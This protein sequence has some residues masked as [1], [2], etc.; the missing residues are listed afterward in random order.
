MDYTSI[1]QYMA[2]RHIEGHDIIMARNFKFPLPI[3]IKDRV[4]LVPSEDKF[5]NLLAEY[6]ATLELAGAVR[7]EV[8]Q[9]D[10]QHQKGDGVSISVVKSFYNPQGQKVCTTDVTYFGRM[11]DGKA[12]FHMVECTDFTSLP[13]TDDVVGLQQA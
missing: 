2:D 1:F 12:T 6:R 5:C 10:A 13:L 4:S 3:F 8:K 9:V 7:V 11:V